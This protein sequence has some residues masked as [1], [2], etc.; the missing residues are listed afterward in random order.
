MV[1]VIAA[2]GT[3][4]KKNISVGTQTA[5]QAQVVDG[6]STSDTVITVGGYGLD[7]GTKV[8]IQA[9]GAKPAAGDKE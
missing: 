5:E 1:M 6:L 3:V 8:K 4:R 9:A 7:D 2:D